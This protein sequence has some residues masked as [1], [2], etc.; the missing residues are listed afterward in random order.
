MKL[1]GPL[2]PKGHKVE[3]QHQAIDVLFHNFGASEWGD[4]NGEDK[5]R[6]RRR[7]GPSDAPAEIV[8]F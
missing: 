5:E 3:K 4:I 7:L 1:Y 6:R 8:M 2:Y